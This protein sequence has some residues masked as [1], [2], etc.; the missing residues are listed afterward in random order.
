MRNK[1]AN[2]I[3][4]D[5]VIIIVVISADE[6]EAEDDG[7]CGEGDGCD[8][9]PPESEAEAIETF[10]SWVRYYSN[11][12]KELRR[13]FAIRAIHMGHYAKCLGLRDPPKKFMSEH[14]GPTAKGEGSYADDN[15]QQQATLQR[16]PSS[17]GRG[18]GLA[19]RRGARRGA[20]S[21]GVGGRSSRV[22]GSGPA[23]RR[24]GH[25]S[26]GRDRRGGRSAATGGGAAPRRDLA[27]YAKHSRVL[28]T[29]EFDS[30]LEPVRKKAKH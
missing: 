16:F 26:T 1:N 22:N 10:V 14:T 9:K 25:E 27:D 23:S 6:A 29:S 11:F 8:A 2:Q 17:S 30:G 12:P 21:V 28:N 4:I 19:G 15:E 13:M 24:G 18:R 20:S 3:A 7:A 5:G